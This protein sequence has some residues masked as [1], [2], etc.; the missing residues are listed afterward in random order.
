MKFIYLS[1]GAIY[2]WWG[3]EV[4]PS[5]APMSTIDSMLQGGK[6]MID[7]KEEWFLVYDPSIPKDR[8]VP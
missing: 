3:K 1:N 7:V 5:I 6:K 4:K 8:W 2:C